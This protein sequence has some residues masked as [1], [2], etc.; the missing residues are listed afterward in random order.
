MISR[1]WKANPRYVSDSELY[2]LTGLSRESFDRLVFLLEPLWLDAQAA[3]VERRR[4][5]PR[6]NAVGAGTV[7]LEFPSRLFLVLVFLRGAVTYRSLEAQYRVGKDT[8]C[9]SVDALCALIP[10]LG[11]TLRDGRVVLNEACLEQLLADMREPEDGESPDG[12]SGA[13]I[14]DGSFT[15]VGRPAT[16]EQQKLL[17]NAHRGV[18]CLVFQTCVNER[19]D[20]LWLSAQSPGSTHDLTALADCSLSPLLRATAVPLLLDKGY[21]GVRHRLGL[22]DDHLVFLPAK[23]PSNGEL[24]QAASF[25]NKAYASLRIKVEHAHS[26]LKNWAVLR[27]YR[28]D[29]AAFTNVLRTIGVLMSL[30]YRT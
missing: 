13:V 21:Q 27:R 26:K 9:R 4:K 7:G 30:H 12:F 14:V 1:W 5:T 8:I 6:V 18:H 29:H 24:D 3:A 10:G 17:Y 19:G 20:L 23:K 2:Q 28:G 25:M 15:Q 11:V 22:R 16:W